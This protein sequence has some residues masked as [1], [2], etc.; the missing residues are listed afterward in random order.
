MSFYDRLTTSINKQK[1]LLCVGLDPILEKIPAHI[2]QDSYPFFA[3]NKAIIDATHDLV[4]AYKPNSAF[5]EALGAQGIQE[6]KMTCD[7]IHSRYPEILIILDAKRADIGNTNEGYVK[8]AFQ[9]L[10]ADAITLQPYLGQE[11]I[12]PFL[13]LKDKGCIILCR[14]SNP[15]ASEFQDLKVSDKTMYKTVAIAIADK[16]NSNNNCMLVVGATYSEELAEIRKLVAD[17]PI[18]VPGIG[19]QGGDLEKTLIAG[20]T[21]EK[22]GVIINAG[23]SIIYASNGEDFAEKARAEAEK[24]NNAIN[25]QR[26]L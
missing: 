20:L 18:L 11:A 17:L 23:R 24:L 10:Q 3:F 26:A 21:A 25:E 15:G 8:Y 7:Y 6:L 12:Q 13:D 5:Y 16:W 1:S 19:A 9:Y 4:M 2:Q 22:S 14:T